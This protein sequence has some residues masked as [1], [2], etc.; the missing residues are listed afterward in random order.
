MWK[1]EEA[2][3]IH[4]TNGTRMTHLAGRFHV[5]TSTMSRILRREGRYSE[6]KESV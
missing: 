5:S 2:I 1:A 4:E 3:E 6:L